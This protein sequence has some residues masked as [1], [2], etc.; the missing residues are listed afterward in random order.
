M[1]ERSPLDA[2]TAQDGAILAEEAGWLMPA[3]YGDAVAEYRAA[4]EGV[5]LFD[6]S[7]RGKVEVF[8]PEAASFLHNLL[9][10]DVKSLP[11]SQGRETFLLNAQARVVAWGLV[12]RLKVFEDHLLAGG[13]DSCWLDLDPGT[14]EKTAKHLQHYLISEDAELADR[15]REKAHIHVAGPGAD[16]LLAGAGVRGLEPG[17]LMQAGWGG[18][19]VQ[20]RRYDRLGV[21]G[22]DVVA[23]AERAAELWRSWREQ[24]ARPAGL[25]AYEVLRVEAGL[26][27]SGRDMDESTLAPEVNRTRQAI[28]YTKGCYLGQEPVV[29]IRDLGHVNRLLVGL[30]VA[31]RDEVPA[32]TKVSHA[33]QDVG[34]LTSAVVSPALGEVAALGYVR[35]GQAEAGTMLHIEAGG[36]TRDAVVS[37]LPLVPPPG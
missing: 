12:Y 32:G 28:S 26:P 16:A 2:V 4:R 6:L 34:R 5:V 9:S 23:P 21:P 29:R 35:R 18:G 1:A 14:G 33:G 24:G 19:T 11:Y 10:N 36:R 22:F 30:K 27:V 13:H 7:H 25:Q 3:H 15:T 31:G 17:T 8:G 37:S 20:F